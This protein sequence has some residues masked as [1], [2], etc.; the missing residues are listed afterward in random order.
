MNGNDL[1][2]TIR[3]RIDIVEVISDYV[4]L[5]R[6]GQRLVSL[7]PF[8]EEKTPSFSVSP[9]RQLYYCFGCHAGGDV[10]SFVMEMEGVPFQE[11]LKLLADRA[12][13]P[14]S[15]WKSDESEE[16]SRGEKVR[17][18]LY[19]L[20]DFSARFYAGQ[21]LSSAGNTA[22]DYFEG[23]GIAED[24]W[25]DY[26]LGYAP[27]SWDNLCDA[28][29][30]RRANMKA[31]ELLGLVRK[32]DKTG[33][34]YDA[35]RNRVIFPICDFRGRVV[36]FG[37]R[38]LGEEQPKYLNSPES[39]IFSK[40]DIWYGLDRAREAIR[41]RKRVILVEGY[42]DVLACAGGGFRE[43]VASMGTAITKSHVRLLSRYARDVYMAYDADRG[44]IDAVLRSAESFTG[45]ELHL[46][47]VSLPEN[48]D[49]DDV[50]SSDGGP[51][52]F[53]ELLSDASP[54]FE[55]CWNEAARRHGARSAEGKVRVLKEIADI[56]LAETDSVV[57]ADRI[58]FAAQNLNVPERAVREQLKRWQV[59]SKKYKG[60]ID[61]HNTKEN[62]GTG[63]FQQRKSA[64]WRAEREL[65]RLAVNKTEFTNNI[66]NHLKLEDFEDETHRALM[67]IILEVGAEDSQSFTDSIVR[68][69][70]GEDERRLAT[71][72]TMEEM[73][74]GAVNR[75]FEDCVRVIKH[76]RKQRRVEELAEVI[77]EKERRGEPVPLEELA[78][79]L[80]LLAELKVSKV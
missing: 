53:E 57:R 45:S 71:R 30:S 67:G 39:P 37:G 26:Q 40:R 47:V 60:D 14:I 73:P 65:L 54:F 17:K 42:M 49:P 59:V 51:G 32:S 76:R 52:I 68:L 3:E 6:S 18:Y 27:D 46:H 10:F 34:Y 55:F 79:Q 31:A 19:R 48:S 43:T 63:L 8:H 38:V 77:S 70:E 11:A 25:K 24:L 75:V 7:C 62:Y 15:E 44:G 28:L 64:A 33:N 80:K 22:R 2:E 61:R 16:P 9:E 41:R 21:L 29:A 13:V 78:E 36:G 1:V 72:L 74:E 69:C 5:E 35:F 4:T 58:R 23:R 66:K 20:A 12:G 50:L 56:I